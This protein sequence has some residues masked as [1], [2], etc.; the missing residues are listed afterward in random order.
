[1]KTAYING[2]ILDGSENMALQTGKV[3][4]VEGKKI[5]AIKD[6][7]GAELSGCELVDLGGQYILPGLINLHVHLPGS[8][9]PSKRKLNLPLLCRALNSCALGRAIGCGMIA[10]NAKNALM[11][12]VTT[13]RAVGTVADFDTRV[14]DD[15]ESGKRIGPRILTSDCAISV[16]GGH[17]A[18]SFAYIAESA[19]QAAELVNKIAEAKPDLIKLMITGG[20]LD[21]DESGEPGAL[22]MSEDC[23]KAACDRAH[24]LGYPVAAHCEGRDGIRAALEN[25]VNTIEHGAAPDGD[26]IRLFKEKGACQVLTIT[27]AL[28]YSLAL[29]GVM[30]LSE[31]SVRNSKI[32]VEGMIELAKENL[33]NGIPVGLGTDSSCSYAT[34]YGFWR[35]L[36]HFVNYCGVS[37]SFALH[38]ATMINAEIAGISDFTGSLHEG[39]MADMIV[40]AE[41]PLEDLSALSR[42][43]KVIFEGRLFDSPE[44]K[45]YPEVE[46]VLN[47]INA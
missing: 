40:T 14:R 21:C 33:K 10:A 8:G 13:V 28:P 20:V 43:T 6:A 30:N 15:I 39:K 31:A 23:I 1:M 42:V 17:M 19:E 47:S 38:T 16:P 37:N 26:I 5:A 34:H 46:Q 4:I 2:I 44:V 25:G 32:V 22:L 35:E 36:V 24:E 45:K 18:G 11:A 27:P 7:D 12:G 9:K 3:I 29:P 41:N